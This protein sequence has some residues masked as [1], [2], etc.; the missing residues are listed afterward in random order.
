[1]CPKTLDFSEVG[2][3]IL[4]LETL[5]LRK[6]KLCIFETFFYFQLRESLPPINIPTPVGSDEALGTQWLSLINELVQEFID[7][8]YSVGIL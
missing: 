1:M 3:Q 6:L 2:C 8:M 7:H 4:Y 5:K